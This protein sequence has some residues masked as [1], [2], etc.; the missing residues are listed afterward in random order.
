MGSW[1]YL[2]ILHSQVT[3]WDYTAD[4]FN[5][6]TSESTALQNFLLA[7]FTIGYLLEAKETSVRKCLNKIKWAILENICVN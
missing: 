5:I 2:F 3:A 7:G 1:F 6:L 4:K